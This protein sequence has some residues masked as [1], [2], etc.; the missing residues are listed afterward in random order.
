MAYDVESIQLSRAQAKLAHLGLHDS[1]TGLPNRRHLSCVMATK[2][3]SATPTNPV[4]A[5]FIDLGR[6]KEITDE[7]GRSATRLRSAGTCS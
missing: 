1:L 7:N 5:L 6:L 4:A 2:L 3:A